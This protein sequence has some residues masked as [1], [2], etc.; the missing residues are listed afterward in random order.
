MIVITVLLLPD[1]GA[2]SGLTE[3]KVGATVAPKPSVSHFNLKE[4]KFTTLIRTIECGC[5]RTLI[6]EGNVVNTAYAS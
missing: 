5:M 4:T 6:A 3:V 1:A 2:V